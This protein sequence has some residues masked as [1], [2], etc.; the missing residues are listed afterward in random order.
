MKQGQ[1]AND[2]MTFKGDKGNKDLLHYH[3]VVSLSVSAQQMLIYS[4]RKKKKQTQKKSRDQKQTGIAGLMQHDLSLVISTNKQY[5]WPN[6]EQR[7]RVVMQFNANT[8][9][10]CNQVI[11]DFFSPRTDGFRH[12]RSC[13]LSHSFTQKNRTL[14]FNPSNCRLW[15][16]MD[17]TKPTGKFYTKSSSSPFSFENPATSLSLLR[18]KPKHKHHFRRGIFRSSYDRLSASVYHWNPW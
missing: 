7:L 18:R 9:N 2:R 10:S 14:H 8:L 15:P 3:P 17:L 5:L 13:S 16:L 12:N 4:L 1:C 6:T 11:P